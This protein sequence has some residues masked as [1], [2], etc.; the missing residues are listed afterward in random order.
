MVSEFAVEDGNEYNKR[1]ISEWQ[2]RPK[3]PKI[4]K[5]EKKGQEAE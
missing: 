1:M 5:I 3:Q 4:F 2:V